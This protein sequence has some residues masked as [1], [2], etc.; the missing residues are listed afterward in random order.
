MMTRNLALGLLGILIVGSFVGGGGWFLTSWESIDFKENKIEISLCTCSGDSVSWDES[1]FRELLGFHFKED[2]SGPVDYLVPFVKMGEENFGIPANGMSWIAQSWAP[3]TYRKEYREN[4]EVLFW[5]D[6]SGIGQEDFEKFENF[7]RNDLPLCSDVKG[8]FVRKFNVI[9]ESI[10]VETE[11]DTF[12]SIQDWRVS[13]FVP[14]LESGELTAQD[15]ILI[16]LNCVEYQ[17]PG[18][19]DED[20]CNYDPKANFDNGECNPK[21]ECGKCDGEE[22]GPGKVYECGC[23]EMPKGACDCRGRKVDAAGV[24]GGA[25]VK[26]NSQGK[27]IEWF[28]SDKDGVWDTQDKCPQEKAQGNGG[29]G[30]NMDVTHNNEAMRFD[31]VGTRSGQKI[32]YVIRRKGQVLKEGVLENHATFPSGKAEANK[33]LKNLSQ[34][35]Q[36]DIEIQFWNKLGDTV[37]HKKTFPNLDWAC[38]SNGHC[39]PFNVNSKIFS[40]D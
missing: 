4:D 8:K 34:T 23:S 15:Q 17:I 22:T 3:T 30:C 27:C 32:K 29:S 28:D 26:V 2:V 13:G 40:D 20:A 7:L 18:C 25:C 24:C 11:D 21:D 37:D 38:A 36:L 31:L 33:V 6:P 12:G 19:T 14:A 10:E 1:E 9:K 39:G 35:A 16:Q 5:A